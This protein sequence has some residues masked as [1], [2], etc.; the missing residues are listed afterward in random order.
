MK[1]TICSLLAVVILVG[2]SGCRSGASG[3]R[4][5]T[6]WSLPSV[7]LPSSKKGDT[8]AKPSEKANA[9]S[10]ADLAQ[11]RVGGGNPAAGPSG[12]DPSLAPDML[13]MARLSQFEGS[14]VPNWADAPALPPGPESVQ[15]PT[16]ERVA[17]NVEP[18]LSLPELPSGNPQMAAV[19][20]AASSGVPSESLPQETSGGL[21]SS[22]DGFASAPAAVPNAAGN[23]M[24][25]L[26]AYPNTD[27]NSAP[28]SVSVP[29]S[30]PAPAPASSQ[31]LFLPGNINP[32]YPSSP[33]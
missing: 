3:K 1:R 12:S 13:E 4:T 9:R 2:L 23:T 20:A 11:Q 30:A 32:N 31:N 14:Q 17:Q 5:M 16:S 25:E 6:D 19:A 18:A 27:S 29:V 15:T 22:L 21:P 26:P 10:T 33:R 7:S 24:T 8:I 28:A